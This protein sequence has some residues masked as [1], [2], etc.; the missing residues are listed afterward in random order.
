MKLSI[1]SILYLFIRII[2][3][4]I[5]FYLIFQYITTFDINIIFF[6]IGLFATFFI[7]IIIS[8]FPAIQNYININNKNT[9]HS[10]NI[11]DYCNTLLLTKEGPLSIIP[12]SQTMFSYMLF[13]IFYILYKYKLINQNLSY[14][15][16]LPLLMVMDIIWN[17]TN[18]CTNTSLMLLG[19]VFGGFGGL[20]FAY[21]IDKNVDLKNFLN[22]DKRIDNCK[23]NA[24]TNTFTCYGKPDSYDNVMQ[25]LRI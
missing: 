18:N 7:V 9:I 19:I 14:L 2:P 17:A 8:K 13:F 6:L 10:P 5:F 1:V 20:I 24:S 12:F 22:L 3:I 23:F 25:S 11:P 15:I 21:I 4:I 16:L